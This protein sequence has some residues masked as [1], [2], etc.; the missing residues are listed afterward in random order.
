M[1]FPSLFF[2][3]SCF[4][5]K[6]FCFL[7]LSHLVVIKALLS[8]RRRAFILL[9]LSSFM[10]D[11]YSP[12]TSSMLA[13]QNAKRLIRKLS[14]QQRFDIVQQYLSLTNRTSTQFSTV[15]EL[16]KHYHI[17]RNVPAKLLSLF[18]TLFHTLRP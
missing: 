5:P 17:S 2:N 7:V 14:P 12:K 10:T 9:P 6:F 8:L 18:N 1:S 16:I 4:H 13:T 11:F 3:H 15:T